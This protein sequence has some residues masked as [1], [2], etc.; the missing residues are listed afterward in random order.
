MSFIM[1]AIKPTNLVSIDIHVKI[2][3]RPVFTFHY[4]Q[5]EGKEIAV[6]L[7]INKKGKLIMRF[8]K[9]FNTKIGNMIFE[10]CLKGLRPAL[11]ILLA[12]S[13]NVIPIVDLSYSIKNF[14][15]VEKTI[16]EYKLNMKF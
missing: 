7:P 9:I 13:S 12:F 3:Y 6:I 1:G 14:E 11:K 8:L 5:K 10:I 2:G 4:N 16:K 15:K